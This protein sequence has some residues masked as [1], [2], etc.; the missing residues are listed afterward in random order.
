MLPIVDTP[1]IQ[2][3]VKKL[4]SVEDPNHHRSCRTPLRTISLV[5]LN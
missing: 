3:I 4:D 2:Y 1:A 5:V